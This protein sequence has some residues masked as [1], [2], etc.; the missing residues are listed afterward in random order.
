MKKRVWTSKTIGDKI[1]IMK[2]SRPI[3]KIIKK[4]AVVAVI[5][6]S[7]AAVS[8]S[9]F[10]V[11]R[12]GYAKGFKE[13]RTIEIRGI[14]DINPNEE[15]K[16][17]FGLFWQAWDKLKS[18]HIYGKDFNDQQ[19]VYGAI[20]GM[21]DSAG[22]PNTN[23]FDPEETKKF[24]D[25]IG[26]AFGGIGAEL[27]EKDHQ[28]IIVSPLKNTPAERIGLKPADIILRV[29][30]TDLSGTT[31]NDAVKL[32]RGEPGTAVKLLVDR[33][34]FDKPRE[35]EIIREI[36]NVP[37]V[38]IKIDE[39]KIALLTLYNFNQNTPSALYEA[40]VKIYMDKAVAIVLDLRNN[41]GGYLDVATN[42]AGWFLERGSPVV[43]EKM[44]TGENEILKTS[45]SGAFKDLPMVV[46]INKGSASA[47]EILAG[48]LRDGRG[49]K[50]VGE[51]SFGKG[52]VQQLE[53]LKDGSS[54][55]ITIAE[56]VTPNGTI[57]QDNGLKPDFEVELTEDDFKNKLDPQLDKA[58]ELIKEEIKK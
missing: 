25:D 57:I 51:T 22:D 2:F 54:M 27:N 11:Y 49:I 30:K 33:E 16:A 10:Y 32:I 34:G 45:G 53:P 47:S 38:D 3:V 55:K 42:A 40:L 56:W 24:N 13:T 5:L 26:G 50:L 7:L 20:K 43:T 14:A 48:A 44:A 1:A 6:V 37:T 58:I 8:A 28:I 39:N 4:L 18:T 23:F 19:M 12:F 29:D 36:I 52:T 17:D 15:V 41:P 35:F 21:V 9:I 46:I 31:V